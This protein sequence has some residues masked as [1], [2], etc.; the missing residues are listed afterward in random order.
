MGEED[1]AAQTSAAMGDQLAA[2]LERLTQFLAG[3]SDVASLNAIVPQAEVAQKVELMSNDV[4]LEGVGNYLSWSRKA[5]LILRT[6]G[7]EGYV[8]GEVSE[9]TDKGSAEWKKWSVR[10]SLIVAWMLNS[11]VPEIA[12]SAEALSNAAIMWDALSKMY[13]GKGNF[14]LMAQI[15]NKVHDL[16]QNEMSVT[17]YVAELRHL[18]AHLDHC[19]PLEL[20]HSECITSVMKWLERRRLMQFLKGLNKPFEGRRVALLHQPTLP[21]LE[22]VIAAM[23]QEEV[24]LKLEKGSETLQQP[25]YMVTERRECYNG[26]ETGH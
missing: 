2:A 5:L 25:S 4:K 15:E 1:L 17:G 13:S 11:L 3:K 12:T 8:L 24:R 9:A 18:W 10:N 16:K 6:K 19:D 14:I 23:S 21:S 26:G 22:E 20:E 7:L